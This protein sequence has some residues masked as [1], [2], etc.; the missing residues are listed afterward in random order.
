MLA[1][2]DA[3]APVPATDQE[4]SLRLGRHRERAGQQSHLMMSTTRAL[5]EDT[6]R[7]PG[8]CLHRSATRRSWRY[9]RLLGPSP[10]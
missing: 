5:L 4:G 8:L 6:V 3:A 7:A 2:S 10:R 9:P 1:C